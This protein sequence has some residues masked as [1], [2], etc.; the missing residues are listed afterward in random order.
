MGKKD[1]KLERR[2]R[3]KKHIRKNL[4]GSTER[5]RM[6]VYR[7]LGQ[8]YVQIIDDTRGH[9]LAAA[10]TK[11]SEVAGQI[12]PDMKKSD[13]SKLVGEAIARK[14]AEKNITEVAFDRNGYL[15]HGRVKALADAARKAGLKF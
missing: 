15:Y 5:P 3:R 1:I 11:D 4:K 6:T 14:A 13:L 12:K 9:T 8:I 2:D 10:S 7:S